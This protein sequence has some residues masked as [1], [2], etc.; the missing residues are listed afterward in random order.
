MTYVVQTDLEDRISSDVVRQILDD[1]ADG[2]A[3]VNPMTRVIADAEGYV[4]GFLTP[5]YDLTALRALG[6]GA[7]S[8]LKRLVLDVAEC[9]LA[10]RHPEYIRAEWIKKLEV[11][12]QELLD[13]RKG[14]TRLNIATAPE[15]AANVGGVVRSGCAD[16]T[17]VRE[18]VFRDPD[19]F[20]VF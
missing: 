19:S 11:T 13:I 16:D 12:R 8:E 18:P 2:A 9:Y 6:T 3:D 15:P 17:D 10:R 5:V 7:P 14:V 20:G 4:E 1:N